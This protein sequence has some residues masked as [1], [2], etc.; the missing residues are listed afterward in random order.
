MRPALF[1]LTIA[2]L[3]FSLPV[4]S[5]ADEFYYEITFAENPAT[6]AGACNYVEHP[7]PGVSFE[8]TM[9]GYFVFDQPTSGVRFRLPDEYLADFAC[10]GAVQTG[11][12]FHYPASGDPN[13]GVDV[14][15]GGCV[16]GA[17]HVFTQTITISDDC[18]LGSIFGPGGTYSD[19]VSIG[20]DAVERIV[21]DVAMCTAP[22]TNLMPADGATDVSLNPT[23]TCTWS[24]PTHC[25]EGLG[26]VTFSVYLGTDPG[27]LEFAGW[28]DYNEVVVGPLQPN[29]TYYWR[30]RVL[31]DYWNCPGVEVAWSPILSFT[32][33]ESV[34]TEE[35]SWGRLKAGYQKKD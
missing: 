20:C 5:T 26:L 16:A 28:Q 10:P 19:I 32:T 30:M 17:V 34:A 33:T 8:Y 31:D 29:T 23:M 2:M 3:V 12:S 7:L 14:A 15:F 4:V 21:E 13:V 27:N 25:V 9:K 6:I 11:L 1:V 35:T 22:P 18:T 24:S